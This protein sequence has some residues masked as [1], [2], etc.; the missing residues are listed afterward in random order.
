MLGPGLQ[1]RRA[2]SRR[3]CAS[4]RPVRL[5]LLACLLA[6]GVAGVTGCGQQSYG[7]NP[8]TNPE[9][10][11]AARQ[12]TPSAQ[13]GGRLSPA[14]ARARRSATELPGTIPAREVATARV[15][16]ESDAVV[17]E[18]PGGAVAPGAPTNAEIQQEIAEAKAAGVSLPSGAS[19]ASFNE[20]PESPIPV[21]ANGTVPPGAE[22]PS[23]SWN[24]LGK[25][26]ADWIVIVLQWGYLHGWSGTVTSGYRTYAE[27]LAINMRGEFSAPAGRSNHETTE[28]PGGAVDVTNSGQLIAVLAGYPGPQKL[29]GGMLGPIDPVHFSATGY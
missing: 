26:V 10:P 27:Q 15:N 12:S 11:A 8:A 19:A 4:A 21:S 22:I 7:T 29:I 6:V 9:S 20:Q 16:A 28:Y 3:R 2:R 14:A 17:A 13:R 5:G 25:P 1:A 24:P 23:A 18:S